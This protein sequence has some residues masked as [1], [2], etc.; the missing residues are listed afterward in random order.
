[1]KDEHEI[2]PSLQAADW[3]DTYLTLHRWTQ[4]VGKIRLAQTPLVNHWWNVP[5]YVNSRGLTTSLMPARCAGGFE[6]QLDFIAH[7]LVIETTDGQ[8]RAVALAPRTVADFYAAVMG[9][10][11]SLGLSV[12]IWTMP[13]EIENP[14]PF[15][16]DTV[17]RSYEPE[18]VRR[19]FDILVATQRV[20]E[21]FRA[22]FLGKCSPVHFFWGA[23]DLAVSRYSGRL[24]PPHLAVPNIA[25][26]V[27]QEAY[28]H[29]VCSA[30]F[31]PGGPPI[32]EPLFFSYAYPEPYGYASAELSP[33]AAHYDE[34]L[35]EYV[36]PYEAVRTAA[37][38]DDALL[39]FLDTSYEAAA[40]LGHWDREALERDR[41]PRL[42]SLRRAVARPRPG[43]Q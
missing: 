40:E 9:A 31:W 1:M 6:I 3:R 11:G 14:I 17:H 10:L 39:E 30:G 35:R 28:S 5:L 32:E 41:A 33:P 23:F 19:F 22:R 24:A 2:W 20:L 36:L 16:E 12:R 26:P 34:T 15:E 13:V 43:A 25:L 4:I 21:K 8:R 29:Q 18:H 38:P 27:V 42:R 7:E 37:S